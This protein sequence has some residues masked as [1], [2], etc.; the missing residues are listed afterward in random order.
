MGQDES[1]VASLAGI[2]IPRAILRRSPLYDAGESAMINSYQF[3]HI[4]KKR[5]IQLQTTL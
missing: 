5:V 1:I 4:G 2:A 3:S